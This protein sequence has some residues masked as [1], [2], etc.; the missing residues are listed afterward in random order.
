MSNPRRRKLAAGSLQSA[1]H[2]FTRKRAG[3]GAN[4]RISE[5]SN[6]HL[7][8]RLSEGKLSPSEGNER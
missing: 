3:T 8:P 2:G 1:N 7:E 5:E 6:Q 4:Q